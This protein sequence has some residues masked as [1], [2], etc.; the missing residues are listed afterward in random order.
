MHVSQTEQT[1]PR[2][3]SRNHDAGWRGEPTA[4]GNKGAEAYDPQQHSLRSP[5]ESTGVLLETCQYCAE[6]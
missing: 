4:I 5:H 3:M 6:S 1:L 2:A